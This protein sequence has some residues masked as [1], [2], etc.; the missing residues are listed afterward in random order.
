[1]ADVGCGMGMAYYI[2]PCTTKVDVCQDVRVTSI[3]T[4]S[5][6]VFGG[7]RTEVVTQAAA[8]SMYILEY[9]H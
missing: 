7:H 3:V 2:T 6:V 8:L 5:Q 4:R 9:H 1:M